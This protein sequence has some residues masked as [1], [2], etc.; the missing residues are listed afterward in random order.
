MASQDALGGP[1]NL[2]LER[3]IVW[4]RHRRTTGLLARST[5][6]VPASVLRNPL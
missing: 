6:D 4:A 1:S 5:A 2:Q 3:S